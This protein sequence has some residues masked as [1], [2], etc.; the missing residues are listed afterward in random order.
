[1]AETAEKKKAPSA[2]KAKEEVKQDAMMQYSLWDTIK[3][4]LGIK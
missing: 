3:Y 1:M 2:P 4:Y